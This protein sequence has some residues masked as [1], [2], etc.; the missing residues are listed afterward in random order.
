MV[1]TYKGKAQAIQ[2]KGKNATGSNKG[3][4]REEARKPSQSEE[5]QE[6]TASL[7]GGSSKF[8]QIDSLRKETPTHTGNPLGVPT[9]ETSE[10][11]PSGV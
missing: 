1:H 4:P 9:G 7:L 6:H 10:Q 5:D 8:I 11:N 3:G 2:T